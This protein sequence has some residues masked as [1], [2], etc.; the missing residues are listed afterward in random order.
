M[1][2][3]ELKSGESIDSALKK[4]KNK[5]RKTKMVEELRERTKFEKKSVKKRKIIKKAIYV[6]QKFKR[7]DD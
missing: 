5:V 2:K 7:N 6:E 4:L 3:V 1:L